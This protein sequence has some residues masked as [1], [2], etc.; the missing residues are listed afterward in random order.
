MINTETD[1]DTPMLFG[2][3]FENMLLDLI[4]NNGRITGLLLY[5]A[6]RFGKIVSLDKFAHNLGMDPRTVRSCAHSAAAK[7][8]I[9]LTRLETQRGQPYQVEALEE[10]KH[11]E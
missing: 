5:H 3:G 4:V 10:E 7:G 6:L 1:T 2:L 11:E 9:K 8:L